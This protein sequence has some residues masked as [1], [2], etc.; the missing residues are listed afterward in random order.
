M[1]R[2]PLPLRLAACLLG[3]MLVLSAFQTSDHEKKASLQGKISSAVT[4]EPIKKVNVILSGHGSNTTVETDEKGEFTFE[5][6]DPGRFSLM[7]QKNGFA[8]SAYGAR[9]NSTAGMPLTLS[10][11]QQMKEL[12]WKLS[13]NSVITGKVLDAE[14]EPIQNA[15]V[16]PMIAAYD[17]G[18]K[19]WAPAGQAMTNDQG[20]YR[21]ANLKAGRYIVMASNLMNNVT[22]S[23]AGAGKPATD[24]PEPSYITTYFPAVTERETASVVEV[25]TGSEIGRIDVH[26]VKVDSFRVKGHWDNPATE[27]K[28]TL[29]VLTPKGAGILGMLSASRTQ[30]NPDGSFEFRGVPPGEYQLSATQD[31]VSPMGT[32]M[33]VQVKDK[34]ISGLVVQ[35]AVP[36]DLPGSFVVEGKDSDKV[37]RK[38]LAA[39]LNPM[40]FIQLNSPK[41]E[42]DESGK[43][44]LKGITPAHYEV[45]ADTGPAQT[46]V[47]SIRYAE[48]EVDD[49]GIDLSA[50]AAGGLQITLSTEGCE[51]KG[52]V[53]GEDGNPMPGVT[54]V[55][56]P[57]SRRLSLFRDTVTDQKGAFDMN[58]IR[59]GDYKLLA[60]EELEPNQF[61][62]PDFLAKYIAKG[63]TVSLSANDKKTLVLHVIPASVTGRK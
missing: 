43:F 55:L 27:G 35:N 21:V 44:L 9:G 50:G 60:W 48:R 54:V 45:R 63:E 34:H 46:Y 42:V 57:D 12:N 38:K 4:G 7:A 10:A 53:N 26:M 62:D 19:M 3:G 36:I 59:P 8:P 37:D 58:K 2:L 51:V 13:P 23:I 1:L 33:P 5:N 29:M 20:E 11:G 56:V 39:R 17:R 15:L 14:G 40:D 24:K 32:Q 28:M 41:A 16:M 22:A 49:D 52:V 18:K 31:F 6:L 47:K 61:Q 25:G 30:L